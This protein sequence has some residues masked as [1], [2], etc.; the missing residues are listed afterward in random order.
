MHAS[1]SMLINY[2][3]RIRSV[4]HKS[5]TMGDAMPAGTGPLPCSRIMGD[6]PGPMGLIMPMME[7]GAEMGA[8]PGLA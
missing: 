3:P 5:R 6:M 2:E 8:R 4:P 1:T 7:R